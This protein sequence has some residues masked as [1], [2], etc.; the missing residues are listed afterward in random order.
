[1]NGGVV[2]QQ[3]SL[4]SHRAQIAGSIRRVG[5]AE[6]VQHLNGGRRRAC[7]AHRRPAA[8]AALAAGEWPGQIRQLANAVEAGLIRAAGRGA[9]RIDRGHLLGDGPRDDARDETFHGATRAFQRQLVARSL[10]REGWNVSAAAR[11][12]D[13]SRSRL[14][15]LIRAFGLERP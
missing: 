10:E 8:L 14:N 4:R 5:V 9:T 15:E 3:R 6:T 7:I 12:L 2:V 1:M 11:R 13:L